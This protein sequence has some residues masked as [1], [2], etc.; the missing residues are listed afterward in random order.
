[1]FFVIGPQLIPL[2]LYIHLL[3]LAD[4]MITAPPEPSGTPR[5][6]QMQRNRLA[7]VH[8]RISQLESEFQAD[9]LALE[10]VAKERQ[11][12]KTEH[13]KLKETIDSFLYDI[14]AAPPE[15]ISRIFVL[16]LPADACVDVEASLRAVPLLLTQV[17]GLWRHIALMTSELWT[18]FSITFHRHRASL[19]RSY[20]RSHPSFEH[21]YNGAHALATAWFERTNNRP[22]LLTLTAFRHSLHRDLV[23]LWAVV[24]ASATPSYPDTATLEHSVYNAPPIVWERIEI[25]FPQLDLVSV[26]S[27]FEAAGIVA[28][29]PR[30]STLVLNVAERPRLNVQSVQYRPRVSNLRFFS[31]PRPSNAL[32]IA[33][34]L[35][36]LE[37]EAELLIEECSTIFQSFP[38]LIHFRI[39][40]I[41]SDSL[42]ALKIGHV[43]PLEL[44]TDDSALLQCLELHPALETLHIE[45]TYTE[46]VPRTLYVLL[47]STTVLPHLRSLSVSEFSVKSTTPGVIDML[48]AGRLPPEAHPC[49]SLFDLAFTRVPAVPAIFTE[50]A[51]EI[52][53]LIKN[54]LRL[55]IHDQAALNS[56]GPW[57]SNMYL[58]L[59]Y[60]LSS[61]G[62]L[63]LSDPIEPAKLNHRHDVELRN[64]TSALNLHLQSVKHVL[65][66]KSLRTA[67][68]PQPK[69]L[70]WQR[71]DQAEK[72]LDAHEHVPLAR[73]NVDFNDL[74]R[75]ES[76]LSDSAGS[77][78]SRV[79]FEVDSPSRDSDF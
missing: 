52:D 77:K 21:P 35:T 54:G 28:P 26:L 51:K 62:V 46:N 6:R 48:R 75:L 17:A 53:S 63:H 5:W 69:F 37:I 3:C 32:S 79:A 11:V 73:T 64:P 43:P 20:P 44:V 71:D 19:E 16:C 7:H 74:S 55:R 31:T 67:R 14:T 42:P 72:A 12:L 41:D 24:Y 58:F 40:S 49:F 27:K 57:N 68:V 47:Q 45:Y 70:H 1:M 59:F 15:I 23:Q 33:P 60:F 2:P 25:T 9:S 10:L 50:S 4:S 22:L 65:A 56:L 39:V 76:T 18:S 38:C 29:F 8:A 61:L 66:R 36:T 30:L 78:S 13:C 34:S